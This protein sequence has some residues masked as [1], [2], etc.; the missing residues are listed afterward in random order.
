M[1][2][3][4]R[5]THMRTMHIKIDN[6]RCQACWDCVNACPRDVIRKVNLFFHKHS[7][8]NQAALC[9]GCFK[10]VKVCKFQAIIKIQK[11]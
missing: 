3:F 9:I 5:S 4:D 10:C 2:R 8:I 7:H 6:R 1:S 11:E